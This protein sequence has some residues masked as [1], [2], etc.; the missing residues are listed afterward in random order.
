MKGAGYRPA[1]RAASATMPALQ[2]VGCA[3]CS[4][5]HRHAV[6]WTYRDESGFSLRNGAGPEHPVVLAAQLLGVASGQLGWMYLSLCVVSLAIGNVF[7]VSG[8]QA[9]A[10]VCLDRAGRGRARLSWPM[11]GM[12]HGRRADPLAGAA[13]GRAGEAV[14]A[15]SARNF[16]TGSCG[17]RAADNSLIALSAQGRS[18]H[19]GRF[20]RPELRPVLARE[21]RMALRAA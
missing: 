21:I 19:V 10:A 4:S 1:T 8:G 12:R 6:G 7:L 13:G 15:W 14:A 17:A 9:G 11:R 18:V 20:V 2:A 5:D 16:A 3:R